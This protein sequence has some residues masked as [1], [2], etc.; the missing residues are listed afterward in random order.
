VLDRQAPDQCG[1]ARVSQRVGNQVGLLRNRIG[2]LS[3]S[4]S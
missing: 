3:V 4:T 2:N 1:F